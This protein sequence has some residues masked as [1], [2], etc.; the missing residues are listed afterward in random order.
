[1]TGCF[2]IAS[3]LNVNFAFHNR[4]GVCAR[5]RSLRV[6]E[7][8]MMTMVR[9]WLSRLIEPIGRFICSF[10]A[11][12]RNSC[13]FPLSPTISLSLSPAPSRS[14][15]L[16]LSFCLSL[17]L[18]TPKIYRITCHVFCFRTHFGEYRKF[19]HIHPVLHA[20]YLLEN[21]C[22]RFSSIMTCNNLGSER[23][24][25]ACLPGCQPSCV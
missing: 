13:I 17:I 4:F 19:G 23:R 5:L 10:V 1:M 15:S 18:G 21:A 25:P 22:R 3:Q 9:R 14:L 16:S 12:F 11:I 20:D 24:V 2:A 6:C 7:G 8:V